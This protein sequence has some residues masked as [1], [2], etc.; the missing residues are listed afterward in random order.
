MKP[1]I[2]WLVTLIFIG[3]ISIGIFTF[4]YMTGNMNNLKIT[5]AEKNLPK[6]IKHYPPVRNFN[7]VFISGNRV[8]W[9][10]S[11][12]PDGPTNKIITMNLQ[13]K[14][15]ETLYIAKNKGVQTDE[16]IMKSNEEIIF[17]NWKEIKP[18]EFWWEINLLNINN[19]FVKKLAAS[20]DHNS[21]LILPRL[22]SDGRYLT[23]LEAY[24]DSKGYH[25][26]LFLFN[27]A[28]DSKQVISSFEQVNN[29][30]EFYKIRNGFTSWIERVGNQKFVKIFD[31]E[32]M[33]V[34]DSVAVGNLA[35][36]PISNEKVLIWAE[37]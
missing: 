23:W 8:S 2:K 14:L 34:T 30:Y 35:R 25:N 26:N 28:D 24:K 15:P 5:H 12:V 32:Q 3:F 37:G 7:N 19:K 22:Q 13:T 16:L 20:S 4:K 6:V 9:V 17:C 21:T 10:E 18:Q 33:K 27:F 36:S 29:P 31:I 11:E 1:N